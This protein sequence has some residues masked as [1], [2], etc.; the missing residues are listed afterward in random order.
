MKKEP[1]TRK[2]WPGSPQPFG[3]STSGANPEEPARPVALTSQAANPSSY[4]P[5]RIRLHEDLRLAG[6]DASTR[7]SCWRGRLGSSM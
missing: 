4:Q 1:T 2:R 3:N 7:S 6:P 5:Q